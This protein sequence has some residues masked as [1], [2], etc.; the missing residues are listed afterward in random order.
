M[1][2]IVRGLPVKEKI[3][4]NRLRKA[5]AKGMK[6]SVETLAL[7]QVSREVDLTLL[8]DTRREKAASGVKVSLNTLV[9]AAVARTLP[10]HPFLNAELVENEIIVYQ[11]VNLGMAVAT[12]LG[13]IVTVI[14]QA[15][16][17]SLAE[18]GER[19]DKLAERARSGKIGLTDIEGGTFTVS[20]LGMY[21]VDAGFP[22]PRP[23]ESAILLLGAIRPRAAVI[24]GKIEARQTCWASLAYDH[25]FIDGAIAAA[26]LGDLNTLVNEPQRLFEQE[27]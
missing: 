20:N 10:A 18:M 25:R 8:Q 3:T 7:S 14:P 9:M 13:L 26:F 17:L 24:D 12:P 5:M 2:E 11:P 21:G 16:T 4:L 27:K 22:L 6:A 19:I 15:E 1:S 23:P